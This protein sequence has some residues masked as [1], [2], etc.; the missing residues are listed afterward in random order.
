MI[1]FY[2]QQISQ[3]LHDHRDWPI[4]FTWNLHEF[5]CEVH[6][7]LKGHLDDE[8]TSSDM[9]NFLLGHSERKNILLIHEF[10]RIYSTAIKDPL[11]K[12]IQQKKMLELELYVNEDIPYS[13]KGCNVCQRK[14]T[15][16]DHFSQVISALLLQI[17]EEKKILKIE[18]HEPTHTFQVTYFGL[19]FYLNACLFH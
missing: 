14:G 8:I 15:V 9:E 7:S 16:V 17:W 2:N 12:L 18:H 6:Q 19:F 3:V 13:R 11:S 4:P 5:G 1:N 10:I